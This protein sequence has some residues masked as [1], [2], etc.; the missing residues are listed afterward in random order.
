MTFADFFDDADVDEWG[1][2]GGDED[3]D[4]DEDEEEDV[5][6]KAS[7]VSATFIGVEA[8]EGSKEGYVYKMGPKGLGYYFDGPVEEVEEEEEGGAEG[9][10]QSR[11]AN[12][13]EQVC[14]YKR[15]LIL[16]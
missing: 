1:G 4:D 12:K 15:I 9:A 11:Y 8:F 7:K 2:K 3:E 10:K 14:E 5:V 6:A 16:Q 13:A